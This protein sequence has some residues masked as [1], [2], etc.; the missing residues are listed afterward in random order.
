[1]S[2]DAE[3]CV[4]VNTKRENIAAHAVFLM[5]IE[6]G[7]QKEIPFQSNLE[8]DSKKIPRQTTT[9]FSFRQRT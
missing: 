1:M 9:G 8:R 6:E 3:N 5:A 7:V 4:S 2:I